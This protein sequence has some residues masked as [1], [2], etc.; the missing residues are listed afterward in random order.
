MTYRTF[1]GCPAAPTGS[2]QHLTWLSL[3]EVSSPFLSLPV[4][5]KGSSTSPEARPKP[6]AL[7]RF[8]GPWM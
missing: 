2:E 4:L 5:R 1:K 3:I 7:R 6:R 8:A